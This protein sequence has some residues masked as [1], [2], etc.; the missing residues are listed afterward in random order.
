MKRDPI[1]TSLV[2]LTNIIVIASIMIIVPDNIPASYI[3]NM[4]SIINLLAAFIILANRR[5]YEEKFTWILIILFL[6]IIGLIIYIFFG[7]DYA[8]IRKNRGNTYSKKLLK[9]SETKTIYPK[10]FITD[11]HNEMDFIKLIDKLTSKP[12]NFYNQTTLLDNGDKF[13]PK[14]FE[15]LSKAK[16]YIHLEYFIIKNSE[17]AN[18]LFD[19][20]CDKAREGVE[21]RAMFDY[22]GSL[23]FNSPKIKELRSLNGKIEFFNPLS[24]KTML[25][26]LNYRNHRKITIIDGKIG[27]TGGINISDEYNH[28]D[29]YYG[30][31]RDSHLMIEGGAVKSLHIVFIKDWYY[32]TNENLLKAK[33]LQD[34][35]IIPKKGYSGVQIIDDGPDSKRSVLKDVYFKAIMEAQHD[36]MIA[37]PY[38]IPDSEILEA[39][40]ISAL[41][42]VRIRVLVPGK[43]DKKL[44]YQA[45]MSYFEELLE[46]GC[47]IYFYGKNFMHSKI[48]V[49][50][51]HIA[52]IG[53]TNIDFRSFHLHFENTAILYKDDTINDIISSF[54]DD[55]NLST[56]VELCTWKKRN[57]YKRFIETFARLFSPLF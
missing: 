9:D 44:V 15:E 3:A 16:E 17:I 50:D 1:K 40:K 6:P 35:E 18:K 28:K 48:M 23:S 51:N 52:S 10:K 22:F 2:I 55:I 5:S 45:T 19:I 39:L 46:C 32:K 41:S 14:L 57:Y 42:G 13:F 24:I 12:I 26:G 56:K 11:F 30:F 38:L 31:W 47:E 37:T 21:I 34:Y 33:Y 20:L 8:L 53:T 49:V 54:E 29:E 36:I 4:I 7:L 25:D 43:P 27:F